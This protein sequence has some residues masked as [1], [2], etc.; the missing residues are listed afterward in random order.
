MP[1]ELWR[2]SANDVSP[3]L[4]NDDWDGSGL[5]LDDYLFEGGENSQFHVVELNRGLRR[6]RRVAVAPELVFHAPGWDAELLP[7]I[8]DKNVSIESSVAM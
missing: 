6:R 8:G 4:W 3:I 5:V 1:E 7:A 2:L